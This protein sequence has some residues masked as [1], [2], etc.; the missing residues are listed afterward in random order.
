M[1]RRRTRAKGGNPQ[2]SARS[3]TMTVALNSALL[4]F[5]PANTGQI[6]LDRA[7]FPGLSRELTTALQWRVRRAQAVF[8]SGTSSQQA[9][10]YAM[11]LTPPD[12]PNILTRSA[13][14]SSGGVCKAVSTQTFRSNTL[15]AQ[16]P[17]LSASASG[18]KLHVEY[19]GVVGAAP[20]G[21]VVGALE[22]VVTFEFRGSTV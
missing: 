21:L 12:F 6:A 15:G 9:G 4:A 5:G 10:T 16:Q 11:V 1:T 3:T 20:A 2:S 18:A 22:V 7:Q 8:I 17:W 19:S 14:T 13:I